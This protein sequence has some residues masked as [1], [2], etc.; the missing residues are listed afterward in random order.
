M[1]ALAMLLSA[2]AALAVAAASTT[3]L[4]RPDSPLDGAI[5]LGVV[6]ATGV[7]ALVGV[8]GLMGVLT[9]A[10]VLGLAC[11][12]ALCAVPPALRAGLPSL[13][14]PRCHP[15]AIRGRGWEAATVALA[16]LA[17]G[18][19]VVVALVLPPYAFDAITYHLTITASW[20]QA[21]NLDP[22]VLSLCCAYYPATSELMFAWPMLFLGT[23]LLVDTVQIGFAVLAALAVAGIA[24]SAGL[25]PPAAA[26]AAGLFAV[27]PIVLTQAPTNYADV[28]IAACA[29]AALHALVRFAQT[30]AAPRLLVAGLATGLVLGIKGIGIVWAAVLAL[31]AVALA[32]RAWR[33]RRLSRRAATAA[34]GAFLIAAVALGGPW[35]AR[36]WIETGNPA[37]PFRVAVAGTT[38]F[39]G[40]LRV[41][42][43]LTP[44]DAGSD[45]PWPAAIVRSW[46]ADLDF[47]N[48]GSY[49]YQQRS[50][51][52]GPLWSW[53]G[54]PLAVVLAAMLVRRRNAALVALGAVTVV[55]LVQ[56]Y[57]WWSRFTIPLAAVG[58]IAIAAAASWAPRP[59][60]RRTVRA[61]ALA[62]A[63]AGV[64]LASVAVDPAARARQIEALDV[65][66]LAGAEPQKRTIGRLFFEEYRFLE[67]VPEDATVVVDL[68]AQPVRFV[69]PLFGRRLERRVRAGGAYPPR[70]TAWVV[71]AA[72]RP[73]D[74]RLQRDPRF[75][76]DS[77]SHGI[78]V[79][80]PR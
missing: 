57:A 16:A 73:L 64:G 78:R 69:Y 4:L 5:T 77:S 46:A 51:G 20:L 76:L 79:W 12:W 32:Y 17:L 72:G 67:R 45:E 71:T 21:E 14:V 34:A 62:L 31:A 6:A 8:A 59:W 38:V 55:L 60:M 10:A 43:V 35:Y 29:L 47:W 58:A 44:P 54:L 3:L 11:A 80:A 9:P 1:V 41:D 70:E 37:Y 56:P 74:G 52:L 75:R 63:V 53:L 19:Q 15:S 33:T 30:A 2:C 7:A 13:R 26:A 40:P 68:R 50:G 65:L 28:I 39:D 22:T 36:N 18:W 48:Q 27:T 24:R 61:A 66:R 49:D 23:D 25:R 42:D